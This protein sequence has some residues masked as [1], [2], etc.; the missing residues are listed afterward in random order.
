MCTTVIK[1]IFMGFLGRSVVNNPS[2]N[3]R[4]GFDPWS[5]RIPHTVEQLSPRATTTEPTH[6]RVYAP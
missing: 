4:G 5:R 1:N 2:V 6:P 3:A